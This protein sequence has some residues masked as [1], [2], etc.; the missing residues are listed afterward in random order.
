MHFVLSFPL[1]NSITITGP[2]FVFLIDYYINGVT[3]NKMQ[4]VGIAFGFA[5]IL[6]NINGDYLMTIIDPTFEIASSF[7]HYTVT[8]VRLKILFSFI[9]VLTNAVWGYAIVVQKK[10]NHVPGIK[11]SF[12]LGIEFVMTSGT[13]I[14]FGNVKPVT[15][16]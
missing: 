12:F 16:S 5:G 6:I 10:I 9:A 11:I 8:D 1:I 3:I 13:T 15:M 14:S 7:E 4:A 2:L